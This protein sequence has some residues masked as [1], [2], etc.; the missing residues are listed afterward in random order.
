MQIDYAEEPELS[1]GE[2]LGLTE[3]VWPGDYS[4]DLTQQALARTIN[5]T[6][7]AEGT[8]V[9][10]ARLLTDGYFFTTVL[11][12]V[13]SPD[14]RRQG[15][16]RELMMRAWERAPTSVLFTAQPTEEPLFAPLAFERTTGGAYARAKP[17]PGR[18]HDADWGEVKQAQEPWNYA[19][20]VELYNDIARGSSGWF[21]EAKG[22]TEENLRGQYRHYP[23]LYPDLQAFA[24]GL[25]DYEQRYDG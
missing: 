3:R 8:L 14:H 13:V 5:L 18:E 20:V 17:R 24:Q 21:F 9:G 1:A 7:R 22:R 4:H 25:Y 19:R 10:C 6:A 12:F 2:F 16:G 23:G 15:I 11:H